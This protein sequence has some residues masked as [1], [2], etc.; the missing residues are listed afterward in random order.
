MKN[1]FWSS[2]PKSRDG[3]RWR[4]Q[5]GSVQ[6]GPRPLQGGRHLSTG[7]LVSSACP[8][9]EVAATSGAFIVVFAAPPTAPVHIAVF[10]VFDMPIVPKVQFAQQSLDH[11]SLRFNRRALY[12]SSWPWGGARRRGSS[13]GVP[14]NIGPQSGANRGN[15]FGFLLF[16]MFTCKAEHS[17]MALW[18]LR[19]CDSG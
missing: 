4:P 15:P 13:R 9:T 3:R 7:C 1:L 14:A 6:M 11:G 17:P 18:Q 5:A 16:P 10:G 19:T 2:A 12:L 8:M